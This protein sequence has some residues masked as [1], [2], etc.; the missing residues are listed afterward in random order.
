MSWSCAL[1]PARASTT[2]HHHVGF[3]DRLP[4]LLGHFLVDAGLRVGLEAA[5]VDHDV[6]VRP[7]FPLP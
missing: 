5:G 4:G 6:L 7:S 3:G 1:M 2:K